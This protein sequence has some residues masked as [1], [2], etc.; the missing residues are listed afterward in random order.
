STSLR[1]AGD[2]MSEAVIAYIRKKKG[3]L[4]GTK[5]AEDL[6]VTV[7]SAMLNKDENGEEIIRTVNARGRDLVS[8]LPKTFEVN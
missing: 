5:T 8:G 3:I 7:G 2:K 4:I 1:H 6:K